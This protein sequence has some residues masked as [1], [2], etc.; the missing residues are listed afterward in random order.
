VNVCAS[1]RRNLSDIMDFRLE[2]LELGVAECYPGLNQAEKRGRS[3]SFV[4]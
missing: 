2:N 3:K 1:D 4:C